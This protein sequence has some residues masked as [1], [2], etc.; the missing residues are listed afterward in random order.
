MKYVKVFE[1][2]SK[3]YFLMED[4]SILGCKSDEVDLFLKKQSKKR[5]R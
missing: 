5:L 4:A 2:T 3:S 1:D